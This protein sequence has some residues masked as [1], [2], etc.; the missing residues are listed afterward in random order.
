MDVQHGHGEVGEWKV[1]LKW[2]ICINSTNLNRTCSK[3]SYLLLMIDM[4]VDATS[5]HDLVNFMDT[6]SRYII[7]S[8]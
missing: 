7:K 6:L 2:R 1:E 5:S 4:M 8:R 3:D